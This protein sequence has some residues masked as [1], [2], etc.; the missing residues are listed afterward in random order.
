M[1]KLPKIKELNAEYKRVLAE[2]KAAYTGYREAKEKMQEYAIARKN[3]ET[4]LGLSRE[5]T[6]QQKKNEQARQ[7]MEETQK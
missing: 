6:E 3:V 2:K 7:K 1:K 4:I 5:Q